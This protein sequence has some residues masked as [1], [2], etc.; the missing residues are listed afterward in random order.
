MWFDEF[1]PTN[2][3]IG[4]YQETGGTVA[5]PFKGLMS[6]FAVWGGIT[7][8]AT[9]AVLSASDVS[10]L[11]ALGPNGN[12]TTASYQNMPGNGSGSFGGSFSGGSSGLR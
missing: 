9:G 12:V 11:Y 10:A 8:N 3:V 5:Q 4:A 1:N 7:A 6:Q 2:F